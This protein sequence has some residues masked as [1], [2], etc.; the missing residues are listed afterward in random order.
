MSH[1]YRRV[2][3]WMDALVTSGA[4]DLKPRPSLTDDVTVDVC[5]VG[6]GLTGL[7][8]AYYLQEADPTL[9]IAILEKDIAGFGA[10]GR[11]GGWSSA[12]FPL[13]SSAL[14]SR[15][16]FD[17]AVA[18]RRAMV[19]TVDEVGRAAAAEDIDCD[20]VR[21]GTVAFVRSSVQLASARAELDEASRFGVDQ[22]SLLGTATVRER[23]GVPSAIAAT[24]T[25]DCARIQPAKLVRGLARVVERRGATIYERTEVQS[26]ADGRVDAVVGSTPR[27]VRAATVVNATE[28]HGSALRQVGRRILPLY[29][30]MI[31]TEP[32]S[33]AVLDRIGIEH[34]QTFTDFRHLLIY[35]QR[36][37]DNRF[38]F[39]GRG[40]RYHLGSAIRP[41]YDRVGRVTHHL[42][43]A[44]V[45]LFPDTADARI[46]HAWG[47]PLG[48]P[49]DWHASV[50]F[51]AGRKEAWA[52]GYV[53]DG[54]STTNLSGRT[55]ADLITGTSSELTS[56]AW[57]NHRSPRWEL[58]PLRFA[59]ANAGLVGMQFADAEERL[60]G[61][62]SVVAR[63]I[64]PLTGH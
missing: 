37:A 63:L 47:G 23:F 42:R 26:W 25:P 27:T 46:T 29:S 9:S 3:F 60:T 28:G 40:A 49:R 18:L 11:N 41:A 12:L 33:D 31:A 30:L 50:G 59:A 8:T 19:E 35:G 64:R 15:Y 21:G 14:E 5:I 2:S 54:V 55:L 48:V 39:G 57:V 52:G 6:G 13:S 44:L 45:D 4:D 22:V 61:R 43:K 1:D 20:F 51:D 38:A 36:T 34:G 62:A 53:G 24:F 58:E 56:L 10:S 17:A 32:L 16:G 7:W